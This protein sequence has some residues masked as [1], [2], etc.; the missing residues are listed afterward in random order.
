MPIYQRKV[1]KGSIMSNGFVMITGASSGIGRE[2]ARQLARKGYSLILV[3]RRGKRLE[4]LAQELV[5]YGCQTEIIT[6]DLSQPKE[7]VR[8]MKETKENESSA[9]DKN[10]VIK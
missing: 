10:D 8:V 3:A 7:C 5:K 2:F 9:S 4:K 1:R 6:A